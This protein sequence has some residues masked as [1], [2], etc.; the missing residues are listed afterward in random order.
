[1]YLL[2]C[3]ETGAKEHR[4]RCHLLQLRMRRSSSKRAIIETPAAR[5]QDRKQNES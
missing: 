2:V 5:D 3:S 1:M 4:K